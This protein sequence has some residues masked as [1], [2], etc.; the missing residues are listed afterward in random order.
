MA[1]WSAGACTPIGELTIV[2]WFPKAL[3]G[4]Y[5]HLFYFNLNYE[6]T[7]SIMWVCQV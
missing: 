3:P 5:E 4:L 7:F 2:S 1:A 6:R